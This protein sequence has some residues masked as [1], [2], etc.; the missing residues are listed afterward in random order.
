MS[1]TKVQNYE[2]ETLRS[3]SALL[4]DSYVD[5]N[6]YA[7]IDNTSFLRIDEL[8]ASVTF[9]K[10][11]GMFLVEYTDSYENPC[12]KEFGRSQ[13]DLDAICALVKELIERYNEED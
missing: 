5:F 4:I 7:A 2:L 12:E 8:N 3:V 9:N 1:D 13:N 6:Y 11:S 10:H